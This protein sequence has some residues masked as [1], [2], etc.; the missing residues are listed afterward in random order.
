MEQEIQ[1]INLSD[2]E[3]D[4]LN[5]RLPESLHQVFDEKDAIKHYIKNSGIVELMVSIGENGFFI[6]EALLVIKNKNGKYTVVEGNRRLTALKLLD[7]PSLAIVSQNKIND[8]RELSTKLPIDELPCIEFENR[9]KVI[10]YLGYKH[11]TGIKSWNALSK[12]VYMEEI[13]RTIE[14][15]DKSLSENEIYIKIARSIGSTRP[16]VARILESLSL[17]RIVQKKD[18]YDIEGLDDKE[19]KF[20]NLSDSLNRSNLRE[21]LIDKDTQ[22]IKKENLKTWTKWFFE[23]ANINKQKVKGISNQLKDLDLIVSSEKA[24]AA[25]NHG[26]T[27]VHAVRLAQDYSVI[28]E[29][30]IQ[31]AIKE[32]EIADDA[33]INVEEPYDTLETDIK[34][35]KKMIAKIENYNYE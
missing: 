26:S 12:A 24:L 6:G 5:P 3:L 17:Y 18:F 13:Y 27:L 35:L 21:F 4:K 19:F 15:E 14:N 34:I 33:L 10:K 22:E 2:L 31:N 8:A 32:L 11:V 1:R 9:E 28:L 20:V 7:N 29:E 25:F 30:S 23:Y 16:Y